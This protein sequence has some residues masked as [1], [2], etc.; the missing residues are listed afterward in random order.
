SILEMQG[1]RARL[2]IKKQEIQA[3]INKIREMLKV[4][5]QGCETFDDLVNQKSKL[6]AECNEI[7]ADIVQI[8]QDIKKRQLLREEVKDTQT[9]KDLKFEA[10]ITVLR[11]RYLSF[12]G[13]KTRIASMRSMAA[14][15]AEEL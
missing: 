11:D 15:I 14:E 2:G 13:D 6:V 10:E 7:D 8:K 1:K 3:K 9:P 5:V 12:A 4:V